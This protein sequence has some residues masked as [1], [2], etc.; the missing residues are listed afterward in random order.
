MTETPGPA[1]HVKPYVHEGLNTKA[2]HFSM[3]EMQSR[4]C[5]TDPHALDLSYTR[6]MM[7]FLAFKPEPRQVAMVGLGGGSLAKFCYRHLPRTHIQVVEINPHV[8]ALRDAF[9][10]P[11]DDPRFKVLLADGADFVR[12][13]DACLE[14][15][16][17]DG[18]DYDGQP[19]QLSS[20]RFYDDCQAALQP[21][22]LLIVN[23]HSDHARFDIFVDRIRRSFD[24]VL[25]VTD[26]QDPSNTIAMAG[27]GKRFDTVLPRALRLP[28]GLKP[29]AVQQLL[30]GL[31]L[32]E[33]ALAQRRRD[34]LDV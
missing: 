6:T 13:A 17:V 14:V 19:A 23:L 8:I 18:F 29:A 9:H 33:A 5:I 26:G 25:L 1:Q 15:L 22:G 20:Q 27:K 21:D 7:G 10:V 28:Q 24:E 30:P 11:P 2:L 16:M 4:M 34:R 12:Q 31:G 32:I 3:G